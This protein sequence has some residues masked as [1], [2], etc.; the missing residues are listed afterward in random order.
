MDH[1]SFI[2]FLG[3]GLCFSFS[4]FFLNAFGPSCVQLLFSLSYFHH[5]FL[6]I[7]FYLFFLHSP[8]PFDKFG[9][10]GHELHGV[11]FC[12]WMDGVLAIF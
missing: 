12:V 3:Y 5:A 8:Y 2:L 1:L 4:L 10:S 11:L 6:S 9:E 7:F